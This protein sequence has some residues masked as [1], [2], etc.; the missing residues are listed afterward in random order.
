LRGTQQIS[1]GK[2]KKLRDHPVAPTHVAP[3]DIGL[4]RC[5]PTHPPRIASRRFAFARHGLAPMAS[6]RPPLAGDLRETTCPPRDR[7]GAPRR[8][9]CHVG[10]GFPPLGP[11]VRICFHSPPVSGTCWTHVTVARSARDRHLLFGS[12]SVPLVSASAQR[13]HQFGRDGLRH[14]AARLQREIGEGIARLAAR[15][16]LAQLFRR[17][18]TAVIL[19]QTLRHERHRD[20][21]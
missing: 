21:G 17:G 8:R 7:R 13:A 14:E 3:A 6:T 16:E 2:S 11:R 19:T 10:V 15:Q 9:P 20:S 5:A 18:N 1:P 12:G 4:R